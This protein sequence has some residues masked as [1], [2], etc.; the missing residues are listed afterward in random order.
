MRWLSLSL[1]AWLLMLGPALALEVRFVPSVPRQGDVVLV[2]VAGESAARM[3]GALGGRPLSFFPLGADQVAVAGVDLEAPAAAMSWE[4]S[5]ADGAGARRW[6]AG[7]LPVAAREFAVQRLT[8]SPR[9]VDLDPETERRALA[10]AARLRAVYATVT[11]ERL[12]SGPFVRPVA[13]EGPGQGFGARRVINGK[14][15]APH[16][17]IDFPAATGTPTLASNRG[18]VVL[19]GDFFF[20]GR[21]VVLDH[22]LG[23]HTLYFHLDRVD[24]VEG[25]L[26]ERGEPIGT[27]GATGRVTGPHLH[28]GAQV[29][30]ARVDPH[31]LFTLPVPVS[32]TDLPP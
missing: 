17:G 9:M 25:T 19:V 6:A 29:G 2:S 7:T 4:V 15:R 11:A 18:R 26:V 12:W 13:G 5:A 14:P 23:L 21:L 20:P 31:L 22:G 28:F 8:L 30:P 10:E 3:A 27:V 16:A 1:F 24:V 32:V